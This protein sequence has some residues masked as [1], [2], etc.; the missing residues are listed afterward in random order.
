MSKHAAFFAR[1]SVA[2]LLCMFAAGLLAQEPNAA[3]FEPAPI[4]LPDA[5][6]PRQMSEVR[7]ILGDKLSAPADPNVKPLRI[8]LC[9]S[10]K[11]QAHAK[12]GLHDYPLWRSR[13]T[14][15]LGMAP[16]IT[17]EPANDWPTAGQWEKAG[18]I[19]IN[20]HNPAWSAEKD[21]AKIA[22]LTAQIDAFLARGGGLVFI[23]WSVS[24]G[25]HSTALA[26]RL[27]LAARPGIRVRGGA[28]DWVLDKNHPLA[29]GFG[30]WQIQ[31]E[32]YWNL[33]GDLAAAN[34]QVLA[35][36][37]E[38]NE[39]RPQMWT[40][41][42]GAGRV[43]VSIPG[44]FTWTHDDPLYRILIL[45]GMMWSARQPIDRLAPLSIVGARVAE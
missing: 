32:S 35:T 17:A 13:W 20:S 2:A 29:A 25:E 27:G 33:I 43:F 28:S 38:E 42:V 31:D 16:G 9:A 24:A 1:L 41:E 39:A 14:R 12:S 36:S 5:P 4:V 7:A 3:P 15:L 8:V 10:E 6:P 18:V 22:E 40:R 23:H 30:A 45:R 21:P 44:H 19:A 37:L 26:A 11:D 34:A